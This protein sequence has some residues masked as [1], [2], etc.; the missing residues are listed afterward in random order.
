LAVS[1]GTFSVRVP[2]GVVAAFLAYHLF[3]VAVLSLPDS[4]VKYRLAPYACAYCDYLGLWQSW[5]MYSPDP[6]RENLILRAR[7]HL[8]DGTAMPFDFPEWRD[9]PFRS[10]FSLGFRS[11]LTLAPA[12]PE[13]LPD[14]ARYVARRIQAASPAVRVDLFWEIQAVPPPEIG[15]RSSALPPARHAPLGS[16]AVGGGTP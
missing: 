14:I 12:Y 11:L 2:R 9:G 6:P 16:F 5:A 15:L 3:G 10:F 4:A 13:A 8:A 7:V 1:D